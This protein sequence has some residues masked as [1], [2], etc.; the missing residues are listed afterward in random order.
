MLERQGLFCFV[1]VSGLMPLHGLCE[2]SYH[3][4]GV[5]GSGMLTSSCL[6]MRYSEHLHCDMLMQP[7]AGLP[8]PESFARRACCMLSAL[9]QQE[10]PSHR[11]SSHA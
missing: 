11:G 8:S 6:L 2:L 1:L 9:L 7:Y 4:A 10:L 5:K 3:I